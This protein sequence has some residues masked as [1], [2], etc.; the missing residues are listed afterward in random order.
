MPVQSVGL[1]MTENMHAMHAVTQPRSAS[2]TV[3][4]YPSLL[5]HKLP[6]PVGWPVEEHP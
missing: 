4:A 5:V 6:V 1:P 2:P 3:V